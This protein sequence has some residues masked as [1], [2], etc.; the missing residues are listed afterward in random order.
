MALGIR[1]AHAWAAAQLSI[2]VDPVEKVN[3]KG[4]TTLNQMFAE[5]ITNALPSQT[6]SAYGS[7]LSGNTVVSVLGKPEPIDLPEIPNLP[8]RADT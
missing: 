6:G 3:D 5:V 2:V 1:F 7:T 4:N 8:G